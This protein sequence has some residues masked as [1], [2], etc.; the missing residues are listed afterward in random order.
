[1]TNC[2]TSKSFLTVSPSR[3]SDWRI[4]SQKK[5]HSTL[6]KILIDNK[7]GSMKS[8]LTL[9]L[10]IKRKK[11]SRMKAP[12]HPLLQTKPDSMLSV[13]QITVNSS[14][15]SKKEMSLETNSTISE[16]SMT[17]RL[18]SKPKTRD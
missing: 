5:M 1:M 16:Q 11:V 12:L 8:K 4:D 10:L 2:V 13:M 17:K 14:H 18:P 7:P 9:M 15:L 6:K 3:S